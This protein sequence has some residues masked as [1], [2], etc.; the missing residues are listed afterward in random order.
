[1]GN[2]VSLATKQVLIMILKY[3]AFPCE[4][5]YYLEAIMGTRDT[6]V[7]AE[8]YR[9]QSNDFSRL[10]ISWKIIN[11]NILLIRNLDRS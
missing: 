6:Q 5:F 4:M 9:L 10:I 3:K 2:L 8:T 7:T 1:M 11:N